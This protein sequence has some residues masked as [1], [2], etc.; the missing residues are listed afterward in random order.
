M[1]NL[2]NLPVRTFRT[3]LLALCATLLLSACFNKKPAVPEPSQL[4]LSAVADEDLNPDSTGRAS[5]LVIRIYALRALAEFEK[6][7]FFALYDKDEQLLAAELVKRDE[8]IIQP[9]KTITLD[10]EFPPDVKFIAVI[11]AFRDVARAEWR[12]STAISPGANG[13]LIVKAGANSITLG[14]EKSKGD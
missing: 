8:I 10:R 13:V 5:P 12:A 3:A 4:A 2:I 1:K 11:G 14:V 9:G 6:A 7:D